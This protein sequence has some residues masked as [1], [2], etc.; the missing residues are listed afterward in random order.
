ME[1]IKFRQE[2]TFPETELDQLNEDL[3]SYHIHKEEFKEKIT[4][5][6]IIDMLNNRESDKLDTV[7]NKD[8]IYEATYREITR[9][10]VYA[11]LDRA[12][13]L[14]YWSEPFQTKEQE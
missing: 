11:W 10:Y 6:D 9:E 5:N 7:M 4:F 3:W 13:C 12:D 8:T 14:L 2:Y 1:A